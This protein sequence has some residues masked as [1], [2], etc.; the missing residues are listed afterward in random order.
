MT[1]RT[2]AGPVDLVPLMR[3]LD[4]DKTAVIVDFERDAAVLALTHLGVATHIVHG[5]VNTSYE[6][7]RALLKK[8][9]MQPILMDNKGEIAWTG[10]AQTSSKQRRDARL[11]QRIEV[12]GRPFHPDAPHGTELAY[13]EFGC[14][15]PKCRSAHAAKLRTDRDKRRMAVAA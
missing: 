14:H 6:V 1:M 12:D 11:A 5:I 7:T 8:H 2:P 4:G 3:R 15:C 13:T 9:G 10:V